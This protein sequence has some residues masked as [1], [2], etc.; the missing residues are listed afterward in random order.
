MNNKDI[1]VVSKLPASKRDE[2]FIK[3]V[4]DFEEV[5]GLF[6]DGWAISEDDNGNPLMPFW[7]KKE[8]ANLCIVGEWKIYKAEQ[9]EHEDFMQE[10]L[11]GI[12][13]D[14]ITTQFFGE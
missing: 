11:P 8:F 3:K 14:G 7:P 2:Y 5:W 9:I 4:A 10:W 13:A 12:K 6:D 1:E